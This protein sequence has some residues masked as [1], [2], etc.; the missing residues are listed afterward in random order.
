MTAVQRRA[1]TLT[2]GQ[3]ILIRRIAERAAAWVRAGRREDLHGVAAILGCILRL[4]LLAAGAYGLWLLVRRWPTVLWAAVPLWCWAAVRSIPKDL[5]EKAEE[6][7]QQTAPAVG[8]E[9]LLPSFTDVREAVWRVG[10]PHAHITALAAELSTTPDRV[11]EALA[12][13]EIPVEPVR[14]QGRG[15]S[16][17]V[18]GHHFPAPPAPSDGVVAA[19]QP[20]N[21]DNNNTVTVTRDYSGAQITVTPIR[22]D[23]AA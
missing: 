1:R 13:C 17:G 7:Q 20:T 2:A 22:R 18:K 9:P 6:Q 8:R 4:V 21:N 5:P 12:A 3:R 19:G 10:T 16:T 15:S 11:R 23:T 14:M